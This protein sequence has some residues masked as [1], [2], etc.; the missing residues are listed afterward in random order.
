MTKL[1]I[2]IILIAFAIVIGALVI[3]QQ[4]SLDNSESQLVSLD[5]TN[6]TGSLDLTAYDLKIT[7]PAGTSVNNG[8]LVFFYTNYQDSVRVTDDSHGEIVY[9]PVQNELDSFIF[10][11]GDSL[12]I[13]NGTFVMDVTSPAHEY[14][15]MCGIVNPVAFN[16]SG[17]CNHTGQSQDEK[18]LVISEITS[19]GV[20]IEFVPVNSTLN[21][22]CIT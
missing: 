1:F 9:E 5:Q 15:R 17:H 18:I 12:V 14:S 3:A 22:V 2:P 8:Q 20:E 6:S 10:Y 11:F 13:N 16:L 21:T 19:Y 7:C 4:I